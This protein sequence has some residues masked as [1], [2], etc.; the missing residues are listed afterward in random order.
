MR[1]REIAPGFFSNET[2]G[3]GS[4]LAQI[5]F[6]SLWCQGDRLGFVEDRPRRVAA[7]AFPYRPDAQSQIDELIDELICGGFVV[8]C[9]INETRLLHVVN[10]TKW[11]HPHPRETASAWALQGKTKARPRTGLGHAKA[12]SSRAGSSV[13]SGPSGP[14]GP[15]DKTKPLSP[16]ATCPVLSVLRT[17][18]ET[19]KPPIRR[20][21]DITG[22]RATTARARLAEPGFADAWPE[23]C[24][25]IAE[26]QFCKGKNDW[27]W[28]AG[29]DFALRP[30]V[31]QRT[32]E[33]EFDSRHA[34]SRTPA[35]EKK[36]ALDP[37]ADAA[38]RSVL[39]D[40]ARERVAAARASQHPSLA[41][42]E[43]QL[44]SLEQS[45]Q[46]AEHAP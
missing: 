25:R 37:G 21:R 15:S 26:S 43:S 39:I 46:G 10:F 29:I 18:N 4:P 9:T 5:L 45:N 7:N 20:A 42:F 13:S 31:W 40:R 2:L 33:G 11:Q 16:A 6:A 28:T 17:W 22:K 8:R 35:A 27:G 24:R 34:R 3:S 23:V 36:P 12:R 32:L 30:G 1:R 38:A 14:S 44:A 41:Q 19:A